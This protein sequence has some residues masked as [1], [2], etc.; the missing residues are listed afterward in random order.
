MMKRLGQGV[1]VVMML[2]SLVGLAWSQEAA[3][4]VESATEP[5]WQ[6]LPPELLRSLQQQGLIRQPQP[7]DWGRIEAPG[8]L[9]L[10][11]LAGAVG[12]AGVLVS[13]LVARPGGPLA[14]G[15]AVYL[16]FG[17]FG[18]LAALLVAAAATGSLYLHVAAGCCTV[19]SGFSVFGWLGPQFQ[20][21]RRWI[22]GPHVG[23]RE[24]SDVAN[25]PD[26]DAQG[27]G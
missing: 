2:V 5:Q 20:I 17:L 16:L 10:A 1:S 22:R 9:V 12:L 26:A 4:P 3:A 25:D 11:L 27:A 8:R 15:A 23:L 6:P 7:C 24:N 13:R 14:E 21:V 18:A 19:L